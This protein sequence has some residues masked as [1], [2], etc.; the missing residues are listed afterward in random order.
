MNSMEKYMKML[1]LTPYADRK[2]M[3]VFPMMIVTYG[4]IAGISQRET[5]ENPAKWLEAMEKTF[6]VTG[7]PDVVMPMCPGDT[8]FV[9]GL[10]A[11]IPGKELGDNELYQF[12]ETPFF[13]DP[14]EYQKILQMGWQN[15]QGM[16]LC[17]IQNPPFEDPA[18]LGAR[19][20]QLG[21]NLGMTMGHIYSHGMVPDFDSATAPIFD[22]LSMARSME[23]FIFD[24]Y[25]DP[26]PIMDIINK[27]QPEA[28][29][30]T[31][32]MLKANN[33]TRVGC[34]AMRSCATF[35]TPQMFEEYAWPGLKGMIERFHA[36]GITLIL[37]ADADWTP[38]LPYFTQV[39]KGSVHIELDGMTDIQKAYDILGGYQSIR[40]DVP[41][42]M[43]C[44]GTPDEVS[45]YCEKL[46]NMGM[47]GGFM[48]GSGCE[49]P[50][51]AKAENIA[52]VIKSV[53]E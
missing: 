45:Q 19:Y 12:V 47:K 52:A 15:W 23:E 36:A 26:G 53:R 31:I 17:R 38:M 33:G 27:Y 32:G 39:P 43:M 46:I 30:A 21:A 18:Q 51:S 28:D 13:D 14:D 40:G 7:R 29:A 50:M 6:A 11:R 4:A 20:G 37:H 34:F 42:T 44:Y 49:V 48:L 5:I 22:T 10:P 35:L 41:A 3:P 8:I 25:D 9:M 24:L 1:S 16:Y 2:E